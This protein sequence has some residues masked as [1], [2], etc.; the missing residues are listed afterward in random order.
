MGVLTDA[1]IEFLKKFHQGLMTDTLINHYA[2]NSGWESVL[3]S[4]IPKI[5]HMFKREKLITLVDPDADL[6]RIAEVVLRVPDIKELLKGM[7]AKVSGSKPVLLKRCI[8]LDERSV[9]E[10]IPN[11][12][13]WIVTQQGGEIVDKYLEAKGAAQIKCEDEVLGFLANAD[14]SGA[15]RRRADFNSTLVFPPGMG[16]SWPDW[17]TGRDEEILSYI[18]SRKPMALALYH[19]NQINETRPLAALMH[20]FGGKVSSRLYALVCGSSNGEGA[21]TKLHTRKQK[22]GI[23]RLLLFYATGQANLRE[24]KSHGYGFVRVSSCGDS[25]DSCKELSKR[26]YSVGTAPQLPHSLCAMPFGCRCSYIPIVK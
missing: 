18:Y 15:A 6:Y 24:W 11:E 20:L 14:Y 9:R 5:I 23:A 2:G 22:E 21:D 7:N 12:S 25:C 3:G 1:Q 8:D 19:P 26:S 4:T 13:Y 16:C 10:L 17:D